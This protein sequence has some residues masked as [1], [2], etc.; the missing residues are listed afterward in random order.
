MNVLEERGTALRAFPYA[1]QLILDSSSWGS[2]A[3]F[4]P[5]LSTNPLCT[6]RSY[7]DCWIC[8]VTRVPWHFIVPKPRCVDGTRYLRRVSI[9]CCAIILAFSSI[10]QFNDSNDIVS[11]RSSCSSWWPYTCSLAP[12]MKG[13]LS[14]NVLSIDTRSICF[15][16]AWRAS[17][18]K[19]VLF[20]AERPSYETVICGVS[21]RFAMMMLSKNEA[22]PTCPANSVR[23][24]SLALS[25]S[26]PPSIHYSASGVAKIHPHAPMSYSSKL[27]PSLT[28]IAVPDIRWR[29]RRSVEWLVSKCW[30]NR[31]G[32]G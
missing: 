29:R 8:D 23:Y 6:I 5:N 31:W 25:T 20:R 15:A 24:E 26:P 13:I 12:I 4:S 18:D 30:K 27:D 19:P 9:C 17:N 1:F 21:L 22:I 14:H 16:D 10:L 3:N 32:W 7:I 11:S 2:I 28:A